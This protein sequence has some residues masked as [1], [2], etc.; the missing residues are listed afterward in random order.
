METILPGILHLNAAQAGIVHAELA[1]P[2]TADFS[3]GDLV[4][5]QGSVDVVML[6]Q[7]IDL[8]VAEVPWL[9]HRIDLDAV[10]GTDTPC[11]ALVAHASVEPLEV[12]RSPESVVAGGIVSYVRD[13]MMPR[14][15]IRETRLF[16][17]LLLVPESPE[18]MQPWAGWMIAAHHVLTD[19]YGISLL[20]RRA[21]EHY[22]ALCSGKK[23]STSLFRDPSLILE[24]EEAYRGS[25]AHGH[26]REHWIHELSEQHT[27]LPYVPSRLTPLLGFAGLSAIQQDAGIGALFDTLYVMRNTPEDDETLEALS[28]ETGLLD[29]EGGDA[30]H[31]PL[32][33]IVHPGDPYRL[34]LAY[35]GDLFTSEAAAAIL[36]D[37]VAA[38]R[39]L[40]E[41]PLAA[42]GTALGAG[43]G[44]DTAM[45][46]GATAALDGESLITRLQRTSSRFPQR[47]ALIEGNTTMSYAGLWERV[48][49]FGTYL[50]SHGIRPGERVAI[51]LPRGIDFVAAIF[52]VLAVGAAYVPLDVTHPDAR[53]AKMLITARASA[54]L[55]D[56]DTAH[57]YVEQHWSDITPKEAAS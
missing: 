19:G 32:T 29:I 48:A 27:K 39:A 13:E 50:I 56:Q 49:D 40:T 11:A 36:D 44:T 24:S 42:L 34:I 4:L 12:Q 22:K 9:G 33:F 16:R 55:L 37:A 57:D 7:A 3:V 30:T 28:A 20:V 26:D 47:T 54:L 35:Q 15:D 51:G 17:Q 46:T 8:A 52:A 53:A 31:Y 41:N 14:I 1:R 18:K 10:P 6:R 5:F 43:S 45:L 2:G 38:L 25:E 21:T 23:A